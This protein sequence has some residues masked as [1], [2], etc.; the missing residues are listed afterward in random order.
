MRSIKEVSSHK[1]EVKKSTF[2]SYLI[3]YSDFHHYHD[4]LRKEHP[5]ANH[6]VF[7]YR[8]LNEHNQIQERASDDGEPK[9]VAGTPT[10][11]VLR[12]ERLIN[13]AI[14]TVRYF[15]G[16]KLGT[17]GMVRAYTQSAKEVIS[18]SKL[19]PYI[20]KELLTIT[21]P[22]TLISRYEHF[23]NSHHIHYHDRTFDCDSV[24]WKIKLSEKEKEYF[25]NFIQTLS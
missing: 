9:G 10:L 16:T 25:D 13:S 11:N 3:P 20:K 2:T 15:G 12:G 14:L 5:K 19:Y 6:I 24:T 4:R 1:Y 17:G 7:A 21:T 18:K 23:F 22:Y 8:I